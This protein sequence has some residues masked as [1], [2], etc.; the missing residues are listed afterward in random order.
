MITTDMK[1]VFTGIF[2]LM[3]VAF[4]SSVP[5]FVAQDEP[6][7]IQYGDTISEQITD[8]TFEIRYVFAGH[9][10]QVV[11]IRMMS[12]GT[13]AGLATPAFQVFS[14]ERSLIDST[15]VFTLSQTVVYA[16]FQLPEDGDYVLV[17]TRRDSE[18]GANSGWFD[19]SL[20]SAAPMEADQLVSGSGSDSTEEYYVISPSDPFALAY[21][22]TG[23]RFSPSITISALRDSG[24]TEQAAEMSGTFLDA[25]TL[26]V[27]P[28]SGVL[29]LVRVGKGFLS[30]STGDVDYTLTFS[31]SEE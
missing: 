8:E 29:Y 22:K 9:E 5:A 31:T 13:D 21:T 12:D 23:G 1:A 28:D 2:A 17:A 3:M 18:A 27:T 4:T 6:I 10:G 14:G 7:P 15:R 16:A 11:I 24:S 25:G 19:L 30:S 20:N 26:T